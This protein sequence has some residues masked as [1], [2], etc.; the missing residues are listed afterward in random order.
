[1]GRFF[2][3]MMAGVAEMERNLIRDR[4]KA[5]M[6]HK[7]SKGE[8]VS[9]FAPFGFQFEGDSVVADEAEQAI[10][11]DIQQLRRGGWSYQKICDAL[12]ERGIPTKNGNTRWQPM[13]VKV[14][15]DRAA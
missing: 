7:Q 11:R 8:R 1:M 5:A 4:T 15:L 13:T 10:I 2:L 6:A 14:I 12:F 3:T 9:R